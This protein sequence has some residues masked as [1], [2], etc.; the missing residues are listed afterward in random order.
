MYS[1]RSHVENDPPVPS[2]PKWVKEDDRLCGNL[3]HFVNRDILSQVPNAKFGTLKKK[4]DELARLFGGK[5]SMVAFNLWADLI[6]F[7]L[8]ENSPLCPQF[9]SLFDVRVTLA[10][11]SH[12]ISDEQ[13]CFILIN[14]APSSYSTVVQTILAS[15]LPADLNPH[16]IVERFSNEEGRCTGRSSSLNSINKIAPVKKKGDK[17]KT[18]VKCYYCKKAGHKAPD[19]R[20][21]KKD[22]ESK[23]TDKDTKDKDK[24][25]SSDKSAKSVNTHVLVPSSAYI[26]EVYD[27]DSDED[28]QIRASAYAAA[29]SRWMVDSG[30]THHITPYKSDFATWSPATGAIRLGGH[31]EIHQIGSG[32]V[33]INPLGG[34]RSVQLTL[35]NIMHVPD[36]QARYF[37][38][39][40]ASRRG[41]R[42]TLDEK[43]LQLSINDQIV[44]KGYREDNLFWFDTSN[45]ALNA[46]RASQPLDTWH[47]RMGHMS[48]KALMRHSDAVNGLTLDPHS[49][50]DLPPCPGCE[51][52]KHT[53][54][55]FHASHK[56]S[57]RI[58][59]IVHS[60][61]AGPMQVRSIRGAY[62]IATFIDD[63]S[64]FGIVYFLKTKDQ[65]VAA[66][67]KFLTWAETQTSKKLLALHSDRGGEYLSCAV[68][69]LLDERGIE[70]KLTMPGSPQQN[71]LAERWNRTILD[72]M[73]SMI[74]SAS[75]VATARLETG[76]KA[77]AGHVP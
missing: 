53:Q 14:S 9:Q 25:K 12:E 13:F 40:A 61:L 73:R 57:D 33:I 56:R 77:E 51:L 58:L 2:D 31:A 18:K 3:A 16:S 49:D 71:G 60:D 52:G 11:R 38:V 62:Y 17:D 34:E 37:S 59:Q 45:P 19:C 48:H 47:Q 66:F 46:H 54:L 7:R 24:G 30:T 15:G 35:H 29:R 41:G 6:N 63:Y 50:R 5:G 68:R 26:S 72:K 28:N 64:R 69:S 10:E 36:A 4:W 39:S 27:T 1:Y 55:P 75:S 23:D 42:I 67:Q 22:E 76:L 32:T 8:E 43:G 65:C 74:H 70:H 20:K 21:K 44:L